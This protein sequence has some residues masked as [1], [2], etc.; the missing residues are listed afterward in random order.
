MV[1]YAIRSIQHKS[2]RTWLT[3]LGIVVGIAAFVVLVGLVDGLKR[4]I[5]EDL[6]E[7]GPRTILVIP[8]NIQEQGAGY[9]TSLRPTSGKLLERDYE[10]LKKIAEIESITKV[11]SGR[12]YVEFKD[13]EVTGGIYGIEPEIF[14]QSLGSIEVEEGRFL[15]ENDRKV[16]V[17]GSTIA[18]EQFDEDIRA[19]SVIKIGGE[20]Y[21][22]VGVLKET[23]NSFAPIDGTIFI[24][25]DEARDMFEN[26]LIEDEISAIR[27]IL[28]EDVDVSDA[29]DKIEREMMASH[30]VTEDE[31]DFGVISSEFINEQFESITGLLTMFL[32]GVGG[33][34][35]VVGGIGIA[36]TM[37]MSLLERRQE[38]GVL[39]SIGAKESEILQIFL[40]ESSLIAILGGAI[41]I[42][43]AFVLVFVINLLVGISGEVTPELALLALVFSAAVGIVSG[44]MP[45]KRAAEIEAVEA[46]RYE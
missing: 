7:F 45:A 10:R 27:I 36:N 20:K 23:G 44:T 33:I 30:R 31:K 6:D 15:T 46:L 39:K 16:A 40:V 4:S 37:F 43:L 12:T 38:I 28:Y 42:V 18:K 9:G 19:N 14:K 24:P 17:L 5:T 2:L 22:I 13:E 8:S 29:V 41:G 11:V 32:G 21:R 25:I 35:L 26:Q 34:A 3:V 1:R